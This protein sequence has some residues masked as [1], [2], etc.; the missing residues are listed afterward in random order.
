MRKESNSNIDFDVGYDCAFGALLSNPQ[1]EK[2]LRT[3]KSNHVIR[4][5]SQ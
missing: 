3:S 4:P 1:T 5:G 2:Q